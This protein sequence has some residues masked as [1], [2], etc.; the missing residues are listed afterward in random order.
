MKVE[1]LEAAER[2]RVFGV[3]EEESVL[4]A[5]RPAM[6]AVL[7]LADDVGE[8]G[9][10]SLLRLQHVYPLD[11]IPQLALFFEVE[12]VTLLIALDEHAEEAEEELQVL[13]GRR[14]RERVDGEVARLLADVQ[15]RCRRRSR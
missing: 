9:D 8:V 4:P 11:R 7:Q 6:Q 13:F 10:G 14:E 5:A 15:V 12:P 3:V 2:E 1:G